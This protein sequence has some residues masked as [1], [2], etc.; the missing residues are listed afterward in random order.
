MT[1]LPAL[2][3]RAVIRKLKRAGLFLTGKQKGSRA[4]RGRIFGIV[5]SQLSVYAH[6]G[7]Y[8]TYVFWATGGGFSG[9]FES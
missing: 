4:Y 5:S 3:A 8:I 9:M 1:R 6:L 2:T 7:Q